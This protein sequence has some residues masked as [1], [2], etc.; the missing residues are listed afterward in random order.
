MIYIFGRIDENE[1]YVTR[2]VIGISELCCVVRGVTVLVGNE[3]TH[4]LDRTGF[5]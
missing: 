5:D 2:K 1:R 3:R 4:K